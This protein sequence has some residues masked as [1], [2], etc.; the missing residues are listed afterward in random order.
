MKETDPWNEFCATAEIVGSARLLLETSTRYKAG[1]INAL[2]EP[3]QQRDNA[4][5]EMHQIRVDR[6]LYVRRILLQVPPPRWQCKLSSLK[7][8]W[9]IT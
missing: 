3:G 1:Q 6:L 2:I 9:A 8:M 5:L 7:D 4:V